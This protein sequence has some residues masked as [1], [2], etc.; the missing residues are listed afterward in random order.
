MELA[1]SFTILRREPAQLSEATVQRNSS[2]S[3]TRST[4][5]EF[6]P[7]PGKPHAAYPPKRSGAQKHLEVR[8]QCPGTNPRDAG[9]QIKI[10]CFGQMRAKPTESAH[11][12]S[13]Q[14][15]RNV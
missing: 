9:E 10:D 3:G 8:F 15:T 5:D 14:R 2:N 7:R 11:N 4:T 12:V 1:E 6:L 13:R